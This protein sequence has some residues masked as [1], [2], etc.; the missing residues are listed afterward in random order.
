VSGV[1]LLIGADEL[2]S[3]KKEITATLGSARPN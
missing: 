3:A 2:S 1:M